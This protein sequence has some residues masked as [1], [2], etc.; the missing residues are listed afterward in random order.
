MS[1]EKNKCQRE[2]CHGHYEFEY[3]SDPGLEIWVCDVC[4]DETIPEAM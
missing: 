4:N 3:I 1:D 2:G